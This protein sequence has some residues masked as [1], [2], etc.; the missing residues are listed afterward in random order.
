MRV[1]TTYREP[2][3]D[4]ISLQNI[5]DSCAGK[6]YYRR[7][8]R[9]DVIFDYAWH[10]TSTRTGYLPVGVYGTVEYHGRFGDGFI[11]FEHLNNTQ[12]L[13]HYYLKEGD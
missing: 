8:V 13:A 9:Q 7:P 1:S 12:S 2:W 10:H 3:Q 11:M 5:R 6:I 4:Y